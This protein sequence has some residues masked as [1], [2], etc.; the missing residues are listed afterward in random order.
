[1][2]KTRIYSIAPTN[3]Q[4]GTLPRMVEAGTAAQA[5]RHVVTGMFA[6]AVAGSLDVVKYMESGGKVEKAKAD[7][8]PAIDAA[9]AGDLLPTPEPGEIIGIDDL[10]VQRMP[11]DYSNEQQAPAEPEQR[12]RRGRRA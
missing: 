11:V 8:G 5:L 2:S 9:L 10:G 3:A 12:H 4:Q 6:I 1:M 7:A